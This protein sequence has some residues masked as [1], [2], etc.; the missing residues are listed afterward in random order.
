MPLYK[1]T[2][3]DNSIF[4]GG[5]T[6]QDSKW[7]QIPDK[8]ILRLE[9]FLSDGEILTL[10]N[11]EAY[12]AFTEATKE[13]VSKLGNCPKCGHAAKL[14]NLIYK[15]SENKE[16]SRRLIARCPSKICN[17]R[18]QPK[19]LVNYATNHRP[20]FKYI[21]GLKDGV[22][23]SFRISLDGTKGKD[24]YPKGDITRRSYPLGKE[25]QNKPIAD[26]VWK[27][28]IQGDK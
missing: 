7:S 24:K 17:W 16:I 12:A 21:M 19:D 5:D 4:L 27:K 9:Y 2:F 15:D 22:V 13:V 28:G 23:K 8:E 1:I 11:C 20:R 3:K 6:V 14:S 26:H 18:G 10:H 25:Y